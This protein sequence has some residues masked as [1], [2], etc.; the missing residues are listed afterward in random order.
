[1]KEQ[2]Q[3]HQERVLEALAAAWRRHPHLR[4]CQLVVVVWGDD[5]FYAKDEDFVQALE[6][7]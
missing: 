2:E 4:L 7:M 5:P 3:N 6:R 1:M